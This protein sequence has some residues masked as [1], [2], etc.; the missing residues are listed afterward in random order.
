M[1]IIFHH[2]NYHFQE[3]TGSWSSLTPGVDCFFSFWCLLD[4]TKIIIYSGSRRPPTILGLGLLPPCCYVKEPIL[5]L[6]TIADP[7]IKVSSHN[8]LWL[9][10]YGHFGGKIANRHKLFFIVASPYELCLASSWRRLAGLILSYILN[11][12][13]GKSK[14]QEIS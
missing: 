7:M 1:T 9:V 12:N 6:S 4:K 5:P 2:R 10:R 3:M 8:S 11:S 14:G 13:A